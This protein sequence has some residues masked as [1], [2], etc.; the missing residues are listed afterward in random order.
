LNPT[1]ERRP[2][3]QELQRELEQ[4]RARVSAL[5]AELVEVQASANAAVAEWQERAYWLDRWHLDL[6]ALMRKPGAAELRAAVR[7]MRSVMRAARQL[8][9][10]LS[11]S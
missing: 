8:R 4:L 3:E 10:R 7:A 6:N 2:S 1:T 5:E 11:G 9:R